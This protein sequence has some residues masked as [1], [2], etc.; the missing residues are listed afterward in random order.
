MKK[1]KEDL[2][3]YVDRNQKRKQGVASVEKWRTRTVSGRADIYLV[4]GKRHLRLVSLTRVSPLR[5]QSHLTHILC[6]K[7]PRVWGLRWGKSG[8]WGASRT[9]HGG[10]RAARLLPYQSEACETDNTLSWLCSR[11]ILGCPGASAKPPPSQVL[12]EAGL[13][14]EL[15]APLPFCILQLPT[16][17]APSARP[18]DP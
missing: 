18:T 2:V 6:A 4:V 17:A 11:R 16:S 9:D 10:E 1:K 7:V 8:V 3:T 12:S 13:G 5:V 14:P 15:V